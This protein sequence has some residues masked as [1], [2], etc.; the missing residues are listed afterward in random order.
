MTKTV[1]MTGGGG[2]LGGYVADKMRE[3]GW[4]VVAIGRNNVDLRRQESVEDINAYLYYGA[5]DYVIHLA[6]NV[7]GIAVTSKQP[8]DSFYDNTMMGVNLIDFV[9]RS[10]PTSH[11]ICMGSVCAYPKWAQLPFRERNLWNGYPEETNGPYGMAKRILLVALDAYKKQYNMDFTYLLST[12]LYGPGDDFDPETSHVIPAIIRKIHTAQR[13]GDQQIKLWGNGMATRDFLYV[14]DA[15]DAIMHI[16][17][18]RERGLQMQNVINMGSDEEISIHE[19]AHKIAHL[20][21][22][23]GEIQF[24]NSPLNGQPR[25]LLDNSQLY[26]LGW[27]PSV[28]FSDGLL[29]T[30]HWW[31]KQHD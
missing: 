28:Y 3:K 19:L 6:A 9:A 27:K 21:D 16:I 24:D 2:F 26:Q 25:R 1:L 13:R 30:I 12:N 29:N 20:M 31:R 7:G 5:P 15:A 4:D 11:F 23:D 22:F 18:C 8:A 17:D 10:M 14:A